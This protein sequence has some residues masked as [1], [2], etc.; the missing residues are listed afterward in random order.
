MDLVNQCLLGQAET[1][2]T[3]RNFT[4]QTA[5]GSFLST[6]KLALVI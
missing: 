6:L 2:D 1:I 5:L 4:K 3:E